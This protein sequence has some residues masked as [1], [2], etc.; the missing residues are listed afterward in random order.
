MHY[1]TAIRTTTPGSRIEHIT[2]VMWL[3]D[4]QGKSGTT[5]RAGAV[6]FIRDGN[7]MQVAGPDSPVEVEVVDAS[8]PYIRTQGN[9]T[10]TDNLL[11][12]PQY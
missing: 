2:D 9:G 12:L 7:R 3:N 8:P 5:T 11:S 1:I 10:S 6:K 4:G